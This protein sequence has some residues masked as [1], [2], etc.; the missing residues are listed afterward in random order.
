AVA[1][2]T[3]DELIA[4]KTVLGAKV[5]GA[6]Q[7]TASVY[8][9]EVLE[10]G[11]RD[12][13]LPGDLKAQFTRVLEARKQAEAAQIERREEIAA[14]RPL[15]NTAQM[16]EENPTLMKLKVLESYE[17]M[18]RAGAKIALPANLIA[19]PFDWTGYTE[20]MKALQQKK[21]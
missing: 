3:L 2:R 9:V 19:E 12:L 14:T 4:E 13:I 7:L 1:A 10:V 20:A 6:L 8:G 5:L 17:K 18:A 15:V 16:L 11:V 21:E